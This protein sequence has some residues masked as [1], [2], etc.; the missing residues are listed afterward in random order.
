MQPN[1]G[2]D[3]AESAYLDALTDDGQTGFVMRLARY[4]GHAV[5]WFWLH[6]FLPEGVVGY[7]DNALPLIGPPEATPLDAAD[8]T[9]EMAGDNAGFVRRVGVR[10]SPSTRV[11]TWRSG[12]IARRTPRMAPGRLRCGFAPNLRPPTAPTCHA[13]GGSKSSGR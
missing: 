5:S 10:T 3:W 12:R 9:H 6:L 4:P 1:I 2:P 11:S 8:V 13:P 7:N